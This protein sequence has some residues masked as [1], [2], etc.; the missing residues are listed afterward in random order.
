MG[1]VK[2][3]SYIFFILFMTL[4]TFAVK[5]VDSTGNPSP[6]V[7]AGAQGVAVT[8]LT[9]G[10]LGFFFVIFIFI[11]AWILLKIWKKL[12]SYQRKEDFLYSVFE[13]N[14]NQTHIN[15]DTLLK[16]RNW[17]FIWIFWKKNPVFIENEK[18]KLEVV[19]SYYGESLKKEGFFMLSVSNK[20]SMFQTIEQIV[21]I[22]LEIQDKIIKKIDVNGGR[23]IIIKCEGL[24]SILNVDYF[25]IPLIKDEKKKN[26]FLDFSNLVY[27]NF[28]EV[29]TYT[30]VINTT[31][32]SYRKGIT[33]SI[34]SNPYIHFNRRGDMNN[35]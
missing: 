26:Q 29:T 31:L 33:K 14:L 35:K 5:V 34:E 17:K 13:T 10:I 27:K 4:N 30:D 20:L 25:L 7:S 12:T 15:H 21:L 6:E 1:I 9:F 28:I 2:K 19:G 8:I 32:M 23:T 18:G 11:F 16:K 22:P 3:I 24:D